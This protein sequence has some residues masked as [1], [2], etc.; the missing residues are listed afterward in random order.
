MRA[1]GSCEQ[2]GEL[3][4]EVRDPTL[5]P[6]A[7]QGGIPRTQ[8]SHN[9][10]IRGLPGAIILKVQAAAA[11]A[12]A[13]AP[14]PESKVRKRRLHFVGVTVYQARQRCEHD[15]PKRASRN[16]PTSQIPSRKSPGNRTGGKRC[17]FVSVK[18]VAAVPT[19]PPTP[20]QHSPQPRYLPARHV[21]T[22]ALSSDALAAR[23]RTRTRRR[24]QKPR[25][26]IS[27]WR[28]G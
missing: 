3:L 14:S 24:T 18:A 16:H 27:R 7:S 15:Q 25:P 6:F 21:H 17:F 5:H 2:L 4:S 12:R 23:D 13:E 20:S 22:W 11:A 1:C 9:H 26:A 8:D 10:Y 28:S 19:H